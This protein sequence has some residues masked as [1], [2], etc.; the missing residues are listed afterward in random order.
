MNTIKIRYFILILNVVPLFLSRI[1]LYHIPL[2]FPVFI[3]II[4]FLNDILLFSYVGAI[5]TFSSLIF[6]IWMFITVYKGKILLEIN[7]LI[8]SIGF[9]CYLIFN[10]LLPVYVN[11]IGQFSLEGERLAGSLLEF[12]TLICIIVILIGFR[13]KAHFK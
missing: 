7:S 12:G 3:I 2:Y 6:V 11:V 13:T 1:Y 9:I 4:M 5:I 10:A 8:I